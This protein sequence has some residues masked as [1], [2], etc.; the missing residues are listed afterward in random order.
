MMKACVYFFNLKDTVRDI[1]LILLP[2]RKKQNN[3]EVL[4]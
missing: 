3:E 2:K 1:I 4:R